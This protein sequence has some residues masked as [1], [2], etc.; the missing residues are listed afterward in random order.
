M[1][2]HRSPA[3]VIRADVD[4]VF[5]Y[6][7][8][9]RGGANDITLLKPAPTFIG[10]ATL[11][12]RLFNLGAY[13]GLLLGGQ[14]AVVG[15]VYAVSPALERQLDQIEEVAPVSTGEYDKR[16]VAVSVQGNGLDCWVYEIHPSRLLHAPEIT[17]GDWIM[18]LHGD[19]GTRDA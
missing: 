5:V 3:P 6:G 19:I 16:R 18:H 4:H 9:R 7:T 12:G 1:P 14:E 11:A 13:P 15:E 8:L 2:D 10:M 17:G